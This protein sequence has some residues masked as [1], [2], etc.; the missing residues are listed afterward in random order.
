MYRFVAILLAT[1]VVL[2]IVA[3]MVYSNP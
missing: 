1:A 3:T 2:V